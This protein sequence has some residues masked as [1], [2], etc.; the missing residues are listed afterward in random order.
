MLKRRLVRHESGVFVLAQGG[1]LEE[2]DET[3]PSKIRALLSTLAR[4]F[5]TVIIDGVN[6]F[7]E[8]ALA[9]IDA[10]NVV[11]LV[12]TQDVLAVRRA[13]RVIDICRQLEVPTTRSARSST[14]IA[15]ARGSIATAYPRDLRS[16]SPR[17]LS[18][19][20]ARRS[21]RKRPGSCFT[22]S[23]VASALRA[24]SPRCIS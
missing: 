20:R 18:R 7:S 10:S 21:A 8:L 12:L 15:A 3:L 23:R 19:T 2:I 24:T 4:N 16:M 13:R 22:R 14:A 9:A 6:D 11:A 5:D 17:R 1:R